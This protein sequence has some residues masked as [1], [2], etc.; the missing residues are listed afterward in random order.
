MT[1]CEHIAALYSLFSLIKLGIII[2]EVSHNFPK[3][4]KYKI[5]WKEALSCNSCSISVMH[6]YTHKDTHLRSLVNF[7]FVSIVSLHDFKN[8]HKVLIVHFISAHLS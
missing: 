6:Q 3:L 4:K 1:D 7:V 8:S 2:A 5:L